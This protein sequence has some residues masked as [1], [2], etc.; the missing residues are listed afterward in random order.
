MARILITG[1]TGLIGGYLCKRLQ[2]G[3]QDVAILSR[4]A[5]NRAQIQTYVW[6]VEKFQIDPEA[7]ATADY[8]IHLSGSSIGAGRWTRKRRQKIIHSRV[9]SG[10]MLLDEIQHQNKKLKAFISAS[11]TGYYGAT[12]SEKIF[13]EA[14]PP[15]DDFLAQTCKKWEQVA[16]S[17]GRLGIKTVKIRT[18]IVFTKEGGALSRIALPVKLGMGSALGS[19]KQ[20]LPWIHIDDLC[21]MY[22]KAIEDMEIRGAYNAVAPEQ[23]TYEELIRELA[24]MCKKAVWLPKIPEIALK[25]LFGKMSEILLRGSRV[26]PERIQTAGYQ[27]QFPTLESALRDIFIESI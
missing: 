21:S 6:D 10:E 12:T 25:L 4:S 18:G 26:S 3:G 8:I 27:F 16:D 2:E 24:R 23:V 1:G 17:I 5:G 19:G 15:G 7:I 9:R 13:T 11:A 20:Y 14:D 22:I